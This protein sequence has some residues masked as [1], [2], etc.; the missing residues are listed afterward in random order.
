MGD[1]VVEVT[2]GSYVDEATGVTTALTSPLKVIVA[3]NGGATTAAITPLTTLAFTS[4]FGGAPK[5][6]AAYQT[7]LQKVASYFG[8]SGINLVQSIPN[9]TSSTDAYGRY[10]AAISKYLN[11]KNVSEFLA[12]NF[13]N[14]TAFQTAFNTAMQAVG[15]MTVTFDASVLSGTSTGGSTGATGGTGTLVVTG[16]AAGFSIPAVT[17]QNIPKPGNQSEFCGALQSDET[18]KSLQAQGGTF[19]VNSCTFSNNVGT[20]N[21]V[22]GIAGVTT[23]PYNLTYTYQ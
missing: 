1:L 4:N 6:A 14:N 2:G 22:L 10:L 7:Q 11:G 21:A 23:V 18:F 12:L 16:Q 3:A 8:L 5:T 9:V 13:A 20:I 19:T 15:G 17:I